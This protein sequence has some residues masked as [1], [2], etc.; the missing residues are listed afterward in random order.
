MFSIFFVAPGSLKLG[1]TSK[2]WCRWG[3]WGGDCGMLQIFS[4]H[5][6]S[7]WPHPQRPQRQRFG[8]WQLS[9]EP[10]KKSGRFRMPS[11]WKYETKHHWYILI[12]RW[13]KRCIPLLSFVHC[14]PLDRCVRWV[15]VTNWRCAAYLCASNLQMF[16]Q[17]IRQENDPTC[18][19]CSATNINIIKESCTVS[20]GRNCRLCCWPVPSRIPH[21]REK[22]N[23]APKS[24]NWNNIN[25]LERWRSLCK[26][27]AHDAVNIGWFFWV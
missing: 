23:Q 27:T 24:L 6:M 4:G 25:S 2:R 12:P 21:H 17:E 22:L 9:E 10:P 7:L 26:T 1:S 16:F 14:I 15:P 19:D 18:N 13:S 3:F 11:H 20:P 5:Q 8:S